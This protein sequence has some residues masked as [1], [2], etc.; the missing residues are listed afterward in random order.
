MPDQ[1]IILHHTSSNTTT[2]ALLYAGEFAVATGTQHTKLWVG[3]GTANRLLLSTNPLDTPLIQPGGVTNNA[4]AL[5]ANRVVLGAGTNEVAV[6]A[7]GAAGQVLTSNGSSAPSWQA[8][9]G[10][11]TIDATAPADP[12]EG[13]LWWSTEE[14]RL[15]IWDDDQEIWI[16]VSAPGGGGGAPGIAEP[17]GAGVFGRTEAG[18]WQAVN[19]LAWGAAI[20][21]S[22]T[23]SVGL[24]LTTS[25]YAAAAQRIVVSGNSH[26]L[27]VRMGSS[28]VYDGIY[29]QHDSTGYQ[30]GGEVVRYGSG[31]HITS[32]APRQPAINIEYS[33]DESASAM[34][35]LAS[36]AASGPSLFFTSAWLY[37][38]PIAIQIGWPTEGGITAQPLVNGN[39]VN[40]SGER[41]M[42]EYEP[43]A[44]VDCGY[45]INSIPLENNVQFDVD[46]R[47]TVV[48][49]GTIPAG[50]YVAVT[51][52]SGLS[53]NSPGGSFTAPN[54]ERGMLIVSDGNVTYTGTSPI[55]LQPVVFAQAPLS[56]L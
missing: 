52:V 42:Y 41:I 13:D 30:G 14:A 19:E 50:F 23:S 40:L 26:G 56:S 45:Y 39:S 25:A 37:S 1:V 3:D 11:A 55:T 16:G 5:T 34:V 36:G 54:F 49:N 15:Y 2:P 18:A 38:H 9:V 47:I 20:S 8:L 46:A 6:M 33:G 31:L 53:F 24:T 17:V 28:A 44:N 43:E 29:I 21:G 32:S 7:A 48:Q 4:A 27:N 35:I 22:A 12:A 10:G 51:L